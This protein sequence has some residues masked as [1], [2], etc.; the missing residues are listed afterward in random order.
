MDQSLRK[1]ALDEGLRDRGA[2]DLDVDL[3][4]VFLLLSLLVEG[5]SV[6]DEVEWQEESQHAD[7]QQTHVHPERVSIQWSHHGHEQ[8]LLQQSKQSTDQRLHPR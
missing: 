3:G 6:A 8:R 2:I 1:A 4:V 7:T 5:A